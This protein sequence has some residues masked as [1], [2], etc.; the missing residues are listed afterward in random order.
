MVKGGGEVGQD[1]DKM[2]SIGC[3]CEVIYFQ[4]MEA[5]LFVFTT[6]S[7]SSPTIHIK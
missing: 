4:G 7:T 2:G 3:R 5:R 1:Y 6:I